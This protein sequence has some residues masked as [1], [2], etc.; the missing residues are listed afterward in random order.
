MQNLNKITQATINLEKTTVLPINTNNTKQTQEITPSIT[1]KEQFETTKILGIY[2]NEDLK[3]ATYINWDNIIEKME[4]L[5][6]IL[7][8]RRLSIYGKTIL[9]NT[10]ILSKASHLSNVFAISAGK[11]NKI[12]YKIFKYLWSNKPAEP[13]ARKT[14]H[15]KQKSG[16]LNLIEP[17]AHNYAVRIKHLMTLNQKEKPPPWKNLATY[18]L[19]SDIHN[20][21]KEFNFLVNNNRTKTINGKKPFY[22]KDITDYIE[23]QNKK[24][25]QIKPETKTIYQNIIQQH[26]KQYKIAGETQWKNHIPNIN[27]EKIWKNTYKSYGQAF[28]KDL[29]YRLLHYSTKTNKYMHKCSRDINPQ[30]DCW[31]TQKITYTYSYSALE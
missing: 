27:F 21:T 4:K 20:Y 26:I 15:L 9:I 2:F 28:T 19:T 7:S 14:I 18:W 11:T 1:F 23:T 8:P 10:L 29:H 17:E 12:N 6:N 31:D 3:N 16:G 25:T 22:Y 5:I 30:C 13:I 24:I